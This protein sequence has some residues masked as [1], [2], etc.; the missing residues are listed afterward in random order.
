MPED[1]INLENLVSRLEMLSSVPRLR[2]LT[3][4]LNEGCIHPEAAAV[5]TGMSPALCGNHLSLLKRSGFCRSNRAGR[6][7]V[8]TADRQTIEKTLKE[9]SSL[10][11]RNPSCPEPPPQTSPE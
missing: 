4:I 11:E 8:Y 6:F 1:P 10:L 5:A 9:L 2:L 3:L 7:L